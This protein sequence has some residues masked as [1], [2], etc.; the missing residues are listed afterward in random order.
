MIAVAHIG[1]GFEK[2]FSYSLKNTRVGIGAFLRRFAEQK[3]GLEEN[4][5]PLRGK[6]VNTPEKVYPAGDRIPDFSRFVGFTTDKY[7]S[8]HIDLSDKSTY[9]YGRGK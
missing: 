4:L 2:T 7:N 9:E 3:I 5:L 1:T 8:A 6:P